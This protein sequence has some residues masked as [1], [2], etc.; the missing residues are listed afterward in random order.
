[1]IK[2]YFFLTLVS[3]VIITSGCVE[4]EA[5]SDSMT[6]QE[7]AVAMGNPEICKAATHPDVCYSAV[8]AS[9]GD[10]S[11]CMRITDSAQRKTCEARAAS[12]TPTEIIEVVE[13]V[14]KTCKYDSECADICVG[15]VRWKQGCNPREGICIK[16]FDYPCQEQ[17][18]NFG[19][20][21]FGKICVS[22]KC[23]RDHVSINA[24]KAELEAEKKQISDEV[25]DM[26]A[27]KQEIQEVW[28]P[29]YYKRCHNALADVT[30][31]LIIDAA[32]MLKSPPSK[33]SDITTSTTQDLANTLLSQ[34]TESMT[35]MS[36]EE[37]IA[38]NCN[39]YDALYQDLAV[40]DT[41]IKHK[42]EE[43]EEI[44]EKL[45]DFP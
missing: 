10:N 35:E 1:M 14:T 43:A 31:K 4:L 33:F 2:N 7:K 28:L 20:Y 40:Y 30:N 13:D 21:S 22:G 12:A 39:Y 26:I 6:T 19:G 3:L 37:F 29:Y 16:T 17:K 32:L 9:N 41:K 11:I 24:K 23:V 45:S 18:E 15:N 34:T 25:K 38:W 5:L 27:S 8:A 42:Q 44:N 36:P